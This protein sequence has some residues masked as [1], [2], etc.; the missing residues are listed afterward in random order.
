MF[1]K[2][3]FITIIL[4]NFFLTQTAF[5]IESKVILDEMNPRTQRIDQKIDDDEIIDLTQ[6]SKE[7]VEHK[8]KMEIQTKNKNV[9]CKGN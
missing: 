3:I 6:K 1:R 2:N 5:S 8:E 7:N 4:S 9:L